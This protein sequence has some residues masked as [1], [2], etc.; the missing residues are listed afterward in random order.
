MS[1]TEIDWYKIFSSQDELQN[2]V[3]RGIPQRLMVGGKKVCLV[4]TSEGYFAV[5]DKCPH[6][7]ASLSNGY[8]SALNTI[9]CPL[10]RYHFDLRTGQAKSG[11]ADRLETF[12]IDIREDGVY[13]GIKRFS[14]KFW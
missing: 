11:I 4:N 9:V 6:N 12:Q 10:H 1:K 5:Q 3:P 2:N 14:W 13:I 8:C 7:G